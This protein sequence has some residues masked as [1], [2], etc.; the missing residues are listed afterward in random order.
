MKV[1]IHTLVIFI[2]AFNLVLDIV[3]VITVDTIRVRGAYAVAA[4]AWLCAIL[5][6]LR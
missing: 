5:S 4:L 6:E 1:D 2:Y 3:L